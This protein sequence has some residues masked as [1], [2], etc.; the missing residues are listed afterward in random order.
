[1][2]MDLMQL[3]TAEGI[4]LAVAIY[5]VVDLTRRSGVV[6]PRFRKA[7]FPMLALSLGALGGALGFAPGETWQA[8]LVAG[9]IA[10]GACIV[11]RDQLRGLQLAARPE[12]PPRRR[13]S[14]G[15][16]ERL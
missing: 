14:A 4:A 10:G 8:S 16:G 15:E 13:S 12:P 7:A 6:P 5:V 1:M 11:A 9:V 2:I 3:L